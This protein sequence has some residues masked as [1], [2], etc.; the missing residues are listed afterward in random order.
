MLHSNLDPKAEAYRVLRTNLEFAAVDHA[1]QTLQVT[2]PAPGEGKSIT[3]ANLSAALAYGGRSVI[4]VDADFRRPMQHK[5]FKVTNNVG[6][7]SA[8][9]GELD[10]ATQ[11]LRETSVPN[12]RILTSGPLPPNPS[13]LLG[14]KRMQQ[15]LTALQLAA[16]IVVI[17]SPPVTAV[18]DT[19]IIASRVD[20]VLLILKA[21]QTRR[22]ALKHAVHAL[23]QVNAHIL[24]AVLNGVQGKESGYYFNYDSS[25]G[26]AYNSRRKVPA[27]SPSSNV[28]GQHVQRGQKSAADAFFGRIRAGSQGH[29]SAPTP[30]PSVVEPNQ[31]RVVP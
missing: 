22:E 7:T 28:G 11:Y 2:S 20:G 8:L 6:V 15:L 3:A 21:G 9:L 12:L 25:Y 23:K 1:L 13:E 31:D 17:D 18:S 24:G 30:T 10:S 14:S 26:Y 5:L 27:S 16:D 4:L 29:T 19:A